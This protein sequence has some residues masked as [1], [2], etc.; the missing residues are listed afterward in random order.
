MCSDDLVAGI[1]NDEFTTEMLHSEGFNAK[2]LMGHRPARSRFFDAV[3]VA[4]LRQFVVRGAHK[5]G[6]LTFDGI[7]ARGAAR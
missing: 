7:D 5:S 1:T 3:C 6:S 4:L 2:I